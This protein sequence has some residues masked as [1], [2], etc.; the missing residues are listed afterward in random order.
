MDCEILMNENIKIGQ[1]APDF[2]AETTMGKINLKDY[3]GKWVVLF[4]HSGVFNSICTTEIIAFSKF[5]ENFKKLNTI[6]LGLSI[7][8]NSAHLAWIYDIYCK[9]GLKVPF[10]IIADKSSMIARKYGMISSEVSNTETLRNVFI[11]DDKG[12]IRLISVYPLNVGRN[13]FEIIRC[14]EALQVSEKNNSATPANW[15]VGDVLTSL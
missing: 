4:S 5:Y 9:T 7:D 1:L 3:R 6:L 13:I 15:K 10:P 14:L 2:E 11:I 8:S 12:I